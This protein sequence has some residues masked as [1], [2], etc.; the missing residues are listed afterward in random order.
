VTLKLFVPVALILGAS[1]GGAVPSAQAAPSQKPAFSPQQQKFDDIVARYNKQRQDAYDD[2]VKAT[3]EAA[4]QAAIAKMSGSAFRAEFEALAS[5]FEGEE[6]AAQSLLWVLRLA[7]GDKGVMQRAIQTLL[8]VY[9]E[10][11]ALADLANQLRYAGNQLGPEP[12]QKALRD[13]FEFSPHDKVRGTALFVLGCVLVSEA[14]TDAEKSEGRKCLERVVAE[15]GQ[16]S[17]GSGTLGKDA[18]GWIFELDHLQVGMVAPDFEAND[19]NG[20]KWKLSDYRGKVVVVDFW[21]YW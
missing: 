18:E 21:G 20:A 15:F 14:K 3:D 17:S 10:S 12:V 19:E 1:L 13:I 4:K 5:E 11:P 2:Y 16:H 9:M 8:E 7:E 6:I